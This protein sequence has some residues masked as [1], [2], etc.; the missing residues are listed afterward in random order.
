MHNGIPAR[1]LAVVRNLSEEQSIVL[2]RSTSDQFFVHCS[3]Y[4]HFVELHFGYKFNPTNYC[5]FLQAVLRFKYPF[6]H[7]D[8]HLNSNG[9]RREIRRELRNEKSNF[10]TTFFRSTKSFPWKTF[11]RCIFTLFKMQ[12]IFFTF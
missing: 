1:Q 3:S 11:A 12:Q 8:Q 7:V 4:I 6:V 10:Q 5:Y 2:N 9:R